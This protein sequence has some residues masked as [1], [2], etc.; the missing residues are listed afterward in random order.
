[1]TLGLTGEL[2]E[3]QGQKQ[4]VLRRV[5]A[6]FM[7]DG[8]IVFEGTVCERITWENESL[9]TRFRTVSASYP[10]EISMISSAAGN[11]S[12]TA[13]ELAAM[14]EALEGSSEGAVSVILRGFVAISNKAVQVLSNPP[15][16][17]QQS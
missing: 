5:V 17:N 4:F 8:S 9:D 6:E 12:P 11:W 7:P 3:L 14:A 2:Q 10:D 16:D 13:Q 15:Q 1:M